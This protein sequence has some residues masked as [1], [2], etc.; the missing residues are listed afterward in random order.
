MSLD[1]YVRTTLFRVGSKWEDL[2]PSC[3]C[4][5]FYA[6][7][8]EEEGARDAGL[9]CVVYSRLCEQ[10]LRYN[11]PWQRRG[12]RLYRRLFMLLLNK[13][14]NAQM[15]NWHYSCLSRLSSFAGVGPSQTAACR[16]WRSIPALVALRGNEQNRRRDIMM[17]YVKSP[18]PSSVGKDRHPRSHESE[19]SVTTLCGTIF[20]LDALRMVW[21]A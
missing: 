4:I 7:C 18:C 12:G 19:S 14:K 3:N 13:N 21:T 11:L 6:H 5:I 1:A 15:S 8:E 9:V 2:E 16:W 10:P 20:K 17:C